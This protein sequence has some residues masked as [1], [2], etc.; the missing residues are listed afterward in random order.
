M[1]IQRG[2]SC[3]E[4]IMCNIM[5]TKIL[6]NLEPITCLF[7]KKT[8]LSKNATLFFIHQKYIWFLKIHSILLLDFFVQNMSNNFLKIALENS[9]SA[10]CTKNSLYKKP[11]RI[12]NNGKNLK[13]MNFMSPLYTSKHELLFSS[14]L[15]PN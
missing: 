7:Y 2:S 8:H 1:I 6:C 14:N 13:V 11:N 10:S 12:Q 5:L 9:N 4:D 3:D 15:I